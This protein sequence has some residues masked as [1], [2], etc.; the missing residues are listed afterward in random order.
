[1]IR[2]YLTRSKLT[3]FQAG[4]LSVPATEKVRDH[5]AACSVCEQERL[6]L[7]HLMNK[8]DGIRPMKP[9]PDFEAVFQQKVR[10]AETGKTVRITSRDRHGLL[11]GGWQWGMGLSSAAGVLLLVAGVLF[12]GSDLFLDKGG[13]F[14]KSVELVE[15]SENMEFYRD[16]E[17]L[18]EMGDFIGPELPKDALEKGTT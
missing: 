6:T 16:L 11:P 14:T 10:E 18:E 8:L 3:A 12:L 13:G 1:M 7:G 17:L 4:E 2:C 15:I 5:L 9:S